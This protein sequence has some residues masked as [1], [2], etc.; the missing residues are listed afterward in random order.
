MIAKGFNFFYEILLI[1]NYIFKYFGLIFII[2]FKCDVIEWGNI[3]F[4]FIKLQHNK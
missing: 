2:I 4:F 3:Y 1:M